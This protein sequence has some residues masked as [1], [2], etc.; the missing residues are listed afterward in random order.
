MVYAGSYSSYSAPSLGTST[1][2]RCDHLKKKKKVS[3]CPGFS[4][5]ETGL[6]G[7]F[8]GCFPRPS[9]NA[10]ILDKESIETAALGVVVPHVYFS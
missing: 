3:E 4:A 10:D 1:Y 9:I 7:R 5:Q 2:G 8:L 6:G